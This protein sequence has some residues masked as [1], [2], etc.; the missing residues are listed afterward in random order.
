MAILWVCRR[1]TYILSA[2]GYKPVSLLSFVKDEGKD[3]VNGYEMPIADAKAA[4]E[5]IAEYNLKNLKP[6]DLR[7]IKAYIK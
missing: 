6:Y 5:L 7:E 3:T 1:G 2:L 4:K